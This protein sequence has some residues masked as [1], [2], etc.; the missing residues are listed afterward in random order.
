MLR[1]PPSRFVPVL[2]PRFPLDHLLAPYAARLCGHALISVPELRHNP[3]FP[4]VPMPLWIDSGGYTL[5]SDPQASVSEHSGL[6]HITLG[7]GFTL[8]PQSVHDAQRG[9]HTGFTLDLPSTSSVT[10]TERRRRAQLSLNNAQWAF[11]QPRTGRLYASVQPGQD[12]AP[13]LELHPDG[14]A[15][16]GLAPHSRDRDHL[17][18]AVRHVR[19]QMP[20]SMPLHVFGLGH[21]ESV[22]A[23]IRAGATSTDSSGPQRRAA[24]GQGWTPGAPLTDPAPHERLHLAVLNL[25][26]SADAGDAA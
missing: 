6:G 14:I 19:D 20:S 8:T 13:Y 5:L 15:M 24:S 18:R 22:R 10:D 26:G 4:P 21:P 12:L 25:Q 9:A 2:S 23:A 1:T 16:G 3:S 7:S 11:T 17:S